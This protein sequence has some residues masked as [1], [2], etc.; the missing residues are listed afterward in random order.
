VRDEKYTA[1]RVAPVETRREFMKPT[2][3]LKL[4][5]SSMAQLLKKYFDGKR[6]TACCWIS[7]VLRVAFI[8]I[9]QKGS[10]LKIDRKIQTI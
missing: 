4:F 2:M 5:P 3:G 1:Q 8:N 10:M 6:D 9:I 7:K